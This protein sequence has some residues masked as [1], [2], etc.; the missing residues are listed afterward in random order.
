MLTAKTLS[1]HQIT[2]AWCDSSLKGTA[3]RNMFPCHDVMLC[4]TTKTATSHI[5]SLCAEKHYHLFHRTDG[6][7]CGNGSFDVSVSFNCTIFPQGLYSLSGKTSYRQISWSLETGRLD[8]IMIV[9]IWNLT[10]ISAALLPI[11]ERLDR[12]KPESC[13]F[14]TSRDLGVRRP[15]A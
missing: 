15:S 8:V 5:T 13:G 3:M 9:S 10:C 7:Y 12:S 4:T 6:L 1:K 11:S 2:A 14:K